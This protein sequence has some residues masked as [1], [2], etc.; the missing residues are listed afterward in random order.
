[1][2]RSATLDRRRKSRR[3]GKKTAAAACEK[4]SSQLEQQLQRIF[5][6]RHKTGQLEL[7][8]AEMAIRATVHQTGADAVTELL[9]LSPP[10]DDRRSIPCTC[11]R[12]A[13]YEEMRSRPDPHRGGLGTY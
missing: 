10:G 8:A 11:G 9:R 5:A 1:M 13:R 2:P 7:D 12:I 4:A 6:D 3:L